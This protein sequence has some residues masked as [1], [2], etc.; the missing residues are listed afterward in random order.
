ML[1]N[2][3]IDKLRDGLK[4]LPQEDIDSAVSY[5]EEYF[6]EAGAENEQSALNEI[7]DPSAVV[8]KIIGEYSLKEI[9]SE[10][11]DEKKPNDSSIKLL[12]I[13]LI[14]LLLSPIAFPL[15]IASFAVAFAFV[16]ATFAL[17]F[18][19]FMV[20]VALSVAGIATLVATFATLFV[21]L[22]TAIFM[23]GASLLML[24]VGIAFILVGWWVIR[25][26]I[27]LITKVCANLLVRRGAK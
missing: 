6:D 10:K 18:A 25:S 26:V 17:L 19:F 14:A 8:S 5:Y 4:M 15:A 16:A 27:R 20:G 11:S 1:R 13:V 7:G 21:H 2:E 24:C 12:W 22:P 9:E 3:F 23:L